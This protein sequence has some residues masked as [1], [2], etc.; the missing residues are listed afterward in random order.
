MVDSIV[1]PSPNAYHVD[2]ARG[3][4]GIKYHVVVY[5]QPVASFDNPELAAFLVDLLTRARSVDYETDAPG[6]Q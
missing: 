3:D 6:V 2:T 4:Q 1:S 5:C